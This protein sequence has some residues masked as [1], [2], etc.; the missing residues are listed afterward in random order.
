MRDDNSN[1]RVLGTEANRGKESLCLLVKSLLHHF[2]IYPLM[3]VSPLASP[4]AHEAFLVSISS[5]ALHF[6][7]F[8]L[9]ININIY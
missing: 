3:S 5:T 7:M 8:G 9:L 1:S 2:M 6:V 4:L